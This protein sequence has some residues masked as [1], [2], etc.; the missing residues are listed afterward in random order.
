[1]VWEDARLTSKFRE[2]ENKAQILSAAGQVF[3]CFC[4]FTKPGNA[5]AI[6]KKL[7]GELGEAIGTEVEADSEELRDARIKNYKDL[8]GSGVVD[9]D[10]SKW[11]DA[12]VRQ[13]ADPHTIGTSDIKYNYSWKGDYKKSAWYSFQEAVKGHR[14]KAFKVLGETFQRMEI[15]AEGGEW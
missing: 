3:E 10:K 15:N 13:E 11:F 1:L 8:L 5:K 7:L 12:A 9:Y 4:A 14:T 2:K 6:K